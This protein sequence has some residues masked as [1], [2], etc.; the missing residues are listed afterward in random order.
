MSIAGI[1]KNQKILIDTLQDDTKSHSESP[2]TNI[3]T[4]WLYW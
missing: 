4:R 2:K 3:K 1:I